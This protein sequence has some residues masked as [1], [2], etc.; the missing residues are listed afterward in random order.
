LCAGVQGL[1]AFYPLRNDQFGTS[2]LPVSTNAALNSRSSLT[3]SSGSR[4]GGAARTGSPRLSSA[5]TGGRYMHRDRETEDGSMAVPPPGTGTG[6]RTAAGKRRRL[7]E[8]HSLSSLSLS[9]SPRPEPRNSFRGDRHHHRR[10]VAYRSKQTRLQH[11]R[12]L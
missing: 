9:K 8:D 5:E 12:E 2:S 6:W 7:L 4:K 11:C 1:P 3:A 10:E